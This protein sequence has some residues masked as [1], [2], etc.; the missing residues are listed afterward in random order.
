[1]GTKPFHTSGVVNLLLNIQFG[2]LDCFETLRVTKYLPGPPLEDAEQVA[3]QLKISDCIQA[4]EPGKTN[5]SYLKNVN[6]HQCVQFKASKVS[7][8]NIIM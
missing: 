3:R 2:R 8:R 4:E 1:M 6:Y 7:H 5:A